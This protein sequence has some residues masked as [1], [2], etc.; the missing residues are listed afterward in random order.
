MDPIADAGASNFLLPL[1]WMLEGCLSQPK[2]VLINVAAGRAKGALFVGDIIYAAGVRRPL[3]SVGRCKEKMNMRLVWEGSAPEIHLVLEHS[4][5]VLCRLGVPNFLPVLS[6]S[7]MQT[8]VQAYTDT[9]L[10]DKPWT[11]KVWEHA[12]GST[13]EEAT[14]GTDGVGNEQTTEPDPTELIPCSNTVV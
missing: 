4:R 14:Y 6:T 12:L 11:R 2:R 10:G 13:F 8:W 1:E 9:V 5:F 3:A 7:D